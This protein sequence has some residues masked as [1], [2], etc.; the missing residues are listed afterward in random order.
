V[1]E[2]GR[3]PAPADRGVPGGHRTRQRP[4]R[5]VPGAHRR[6]PRPGRR[7]SGLRR[8]LALVV[9]AALL[10]AGCETDVDEGPVELTFAFGPD[11]SGTL[12]PLIERFNE[13]NDQQITV[14]WREMPRESD[15]YF[16][17]VVAEFEA[18]DSDIDV[19]AS[20]VVWTAEL[21]AAGHVSDLG[22]RIASDLS[23]DDF[24]APAWSS[25]TY[26]QR[27]WGVPWYTDAGVLLY[28]ADL[29]RDAGYDEPPETW[30]EL[31]EM[32]VA[33]TAEADVP[34]GFVFQGADYEGGAVNLLEH[35][36]SFGGRV[37]TTRASVAG[38]FGQSVMAPN[39]I[40]VDSAR[41]VEGLDHARS[42]I[43]D[44]IA[45]EEVV[46]YREVESD[47]AF[48]QGDAVFLRSWPLAVAIAAAEGLEL[49]QVGAAPLPVARAGDPSFSAL[50][51]W[52]L[53]LVDDSDHH[54]AGWEFVRFLTDEEQ[55]RVRAGDGA[56]LPTLEALYADD[57]LA[58]QQPVLAVGR[59][60]VE[61]ARLR[62][63]SPDY[64]TI[65][66]LLATGFHEVLRGEQDGATVAARLQRDLEAVV[67]R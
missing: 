15:A 54:D 31:R 64:S 56:F 33:V 60:A 46:E 66:P 35:Q 16:A 3:D 59:Q 26:E 48:A 63:V 67:S 17:E 65:S 14:T 25:G 34:H 36:W 11:E 18:G 39:V 4:D 57:D 24:V 30:E 7:P 12:E 21:A 20:D 2:H 38:A 29:L 49:D 6:R 44:G 32:A 45:P 13:T 9:A 58:E 62:P 51:G 47:A 42:L 22:A 52:N 19:L 5:D 43:E 8:G 61:D 10:A 50:G 41:T 23:A 27:Q 40:V 28:R 55:Q 37:L 1:T 53:M